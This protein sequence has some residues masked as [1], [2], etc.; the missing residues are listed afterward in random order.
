MS[1]AECGAICVRKDVMDKFNIIM[2]D[3]KL[4]ANE[5]MEHLFNLH[6]G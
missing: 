2:T 4:D 3:T 6:T 1:D 5:L